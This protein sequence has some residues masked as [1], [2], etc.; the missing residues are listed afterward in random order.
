MGSHS[1]LQG[2][3]SWPRDWTQVSCI[4]GRLLRE[5]A[6]GCARGY[7]EGSPA[8]RKAA[9]GAQVYGSRPGSLERGPVWSGCMPLPRRP[10]LLQCSP[11]LSMRSSKAGP[12]QSRDWVPTHMWPWRCEQTGIL[13]HQ[14]SPN[15]SCSEQWLVMLI[16]Q[17]M[18]VIIIILSGKIIHV[19]HPSVS[20]SHL[21]KSFPDIPW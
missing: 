2:V 8:L 21:Q 15:I 9:L 4:A 17:W 3:S 1:L 16:A 14:R 13:R 5:V 18:L 20:A 12:P 11:G 10:P 6:G 7:S 19:S